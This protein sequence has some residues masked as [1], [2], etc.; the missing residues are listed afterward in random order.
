[1]KHT[2]QVTGMTC[3]GCRSHVEKSLSEIPG[4]IGVEV[5]LEKRLAQIEMEKHIPLERFQEKLAEEGD[6]YQIDLPQ[7]EQHHK[8]MVEVIQLGWLVR[9]P[10]P[11]R[12][13]HLRVPEFSTAQCI[14]RAKKPMTSTET[15]QYAGW[16]L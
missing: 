5:D 11:K 8:Q 16:T 13:Q 12:K 9:N 10:S 7:N 15:V 1:M 4:V 14:A 2:Y 3:N 6:R